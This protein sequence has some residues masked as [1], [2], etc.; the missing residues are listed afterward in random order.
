M[1]TCMRMEVFIFARFHAR[2]GNK[3]AVA[4]ALLDILRSYAR[5]A[6]LPEYSRIS[7]NS[8]PAA[9]AARIPQAC[10]SGAVEIRPVEQYF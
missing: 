5:G 1:G 7:V 4:E 3:G 10:L 2:P 8:R 6:G 9:L